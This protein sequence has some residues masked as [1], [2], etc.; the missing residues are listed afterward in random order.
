MTENKRLKR[1]AAFLAALLMLLPCAGCS[2]NNGSQGG[3]GNASSASDQNNASSVKLPKRAAKL[4][5]EQK[6]DA[7]DKNISEERF[8]TDN[9]QITKVAED[10]LKQYC[11]GMTEADHDKCFDVFPAF[12]KKAVE[13]ENSECGDTNEQY[14]QSIKKGFAD[15]Y[16]DDFYIFPTVTSVL[17][18][19]DESLEGTEERL[20]KSFGEDISLDDLYYVYFNENVRGS[21]N[22]SSDALEFFILVM[23]ENCY[24]YD[25]YYETADEEN[26]GAVKEPEEKAN[27]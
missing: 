17:Q 22:K 21:K 8:C 15:S 4:T 24:L 1:S 18:L 25:D 14:M 26:N 9:E 11:D 23:D 6:K 19:S 3:G 27:S 10:L 20:K 16:G 13:K 7:S 5:D 12:Y 2:G